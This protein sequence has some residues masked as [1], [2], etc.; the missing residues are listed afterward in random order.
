MLPATATLNIAPICDNEFLTRGEELWKN[1]HSLYDLD[2]GNLAPYFRESCAKK[3][4]CKIVRPELVKAKPC[5]VQEV[6][7]KTLNHEQSTQAGGDFEFV[8]NRSTNIQAF[9]IW[10][11]TTFPNGVTFSTGP[12][13]Q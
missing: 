12:T 3:L 13:D 8:M 5:V 9:C 4:Y 1:F 6:N 2:L 7:F 10:F 11:T